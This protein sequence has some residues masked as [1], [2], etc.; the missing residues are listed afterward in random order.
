MFLKQVMKFL[1]IIV[2][3]P[4]IVRAENV[5]AIYLAQTP[6]SGPKMKHVNITYYF[7][8]DYIEDGVVKIIFVRSEDK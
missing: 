4:I 3:L 5:R 8:W 1:S 2:A 7:V 6:M